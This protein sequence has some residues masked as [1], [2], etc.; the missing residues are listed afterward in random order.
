MKASD[1][2]NA[3][4]GSVLMI[5][6][7]GGEYNIEKNDV[8]NGNILAKKEIKNLIVNN[9]SVLM[10]MRM[11]PGDVEGHTNLSTGEYVPGVITG[12]YNTSGLKYLAVG[13]GLLVDPTKIY[14]ENTNPSTWD[15][16]NPPE[17]TLETVQ[18]AGELYRKNFTDWKFLDATGN[19]SQSPTNVILLSTTFLESEAVGPLVEMGIF[20][21][22]SA[23]GAKNTGM[24]FNYKTFKVWNKP[25]DCRLSI[26][27]KLTF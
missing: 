9:A 27:W 3:P 10:A 7:K 19:L 21:D 4:S 25:G 14:D 8:I 12:E 20:G 1:I 24:M 17:E 15:L 18:L 26:I 22:N 6:H 13:T 11:A 23:T 2:F 5:L 16:Q